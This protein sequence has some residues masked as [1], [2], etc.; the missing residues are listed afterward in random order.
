MKVRCLLIALA[1]FAA[2][3]TDSWG[4]SKQPSPSS[5][6]PSKQIMQQAAPDQRGTE[7]SPAIV[8]I[9]PT[10][11]TAEEVDADRKDRED[12]NRSDSWLVKLTGALAFIGFLQLI[13]FGWQGIQLKRSVSAAKDATELGNKEFI[14]TH[15]PKVIVRYIQGPFHDEQGKGFIWVTVVNTGINAATIEAFGADLA[16]RMD[17]TE[18]WVA[19]G[20]DA[21]AKEIEPIVLTCGQRHAF[22]VVAK[23]TVGDE[24]ILRDA[25]GDSQLC[26][27]GEIRYRDGNGVVRDT[28][29]FRV[30]SEVDERFIPSDHDSE[31][32][33]QD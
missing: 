22:T 28:G 17:E 8:R 18:E 30:W 7:Q 4:Q 12:K 11:K 29:F 26:A 5:N 6:P 25:L 23:T 20:L 3:A 24:E 21:S 13:V 15:R 31:M 14:A 1:L 32:E 10:P 9:L 16:R 33:Y 19:P 27:V 2:F